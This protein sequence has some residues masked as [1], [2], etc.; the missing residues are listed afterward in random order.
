MLRIDVNSMNTEVYTPYQDNPEYK[1]ALLKFKE[2][3]KTGEE[4]E[5]GDSETE[6]ETMVSQ[7][8]YSKGF[9]DGMRFILNA[10]AGKEVIRLY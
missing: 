7:I 6:V 10:M 4:I 2:A 3:L 1:M 5:I 9:H 8:S